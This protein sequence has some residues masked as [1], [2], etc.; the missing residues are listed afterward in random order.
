MSSPQSG[1]AVAGVHAEAQD[2]P[3]IIQHKAPN[4]HIPEEHAFGKPR[5][6]RHEHH[7]DGA[8]IAG[9]GDKGGGVGRVHRQH[10]HQP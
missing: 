2:Q 1:D 5:E 8:R 6:R 3:G 4:E 7:F 10:H 9:G